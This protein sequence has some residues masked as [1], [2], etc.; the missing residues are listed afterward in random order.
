NFPGDCE[1]LVTKRMDTASGP[2]ME[3]EFSIDAAR[4]EGW[5]DQY[6]LIP[7]PPY[8]HREVARSAPNSQDR[9]R[10]QTVR[11]RQKRSVAAPTAG[12]HFTPQILAHLEERGVSICPV[13]LH[14]GAGTFLPVKTQDPSQHRMHSENF[15]IQRESY[16]K[17]IAA[18][19]QEK[20]II[21]VGT[22]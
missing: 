11:A 3:I 13:T 8:I 2:A 20:P 10:Y 12:L 4:F 1:G 9:A 5:L 21:V 22:T 18:L 19:D 7:L 15:M 17:I 14:V 16:Q 6:G